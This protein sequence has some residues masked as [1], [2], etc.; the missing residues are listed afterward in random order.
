M[1]ISMVAFIAAVQAAQPGP[2]DLSGVTVQPPVFRTAEALR[3]WADVHSNLSGVADGLSY[4]FD[5]PL[6][7]D[8]AP[9]LAGLQGAAVWR[10]SPE[11]QALLVT[12]NLGEVTAANYDAFERDELLQAAHLRTLYFVTA[13]PA[14]HGAYSDELVSYALAVRT[15]REVGGESASDLPVGFATPVTVSIPVAGENV[16]TLVASLSLRVD[17]TLRGF[18]GRAV[19]CGGFR[20]SFTYPGVPQR[21]EVPHLRECLVPA[22]LTRI[23]LVR[24]ASGAPVREWPRGDRGPSVETPATAAGVEPSDRQR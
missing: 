23:A 1:L 3:A 22:A 16:G 6:R 10:Y 11:A 18:D 9:G 15:S 7:P 13:R 20:G 5:L 14:V 24:T 12:T 4:R 17:G 2:V 19:L 8:T 21:V